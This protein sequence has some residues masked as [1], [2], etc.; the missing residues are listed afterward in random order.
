MS[1]SARL[2]TTALL[3]CLAQLASAQTPA[4]APDPDVV[5]IRSD[6]EFGKYDD[7]LKRARE[8]IDRGGLS[9]DQTLELH[10]IAGLSAFNLGKPEDAERH[11]GAV[12]R[13]DPD[14]AMDPFTVPPPAIALF[15]KIR[16]D[17]GATL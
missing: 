5:S 1:R 6:Y 10:R 12:L 16:K 11:F 14:Y 9:E 17:M 2:L 4:P 13:L 15:E 8:R 3:C 7:A